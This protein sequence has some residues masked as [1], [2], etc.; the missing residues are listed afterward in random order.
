MR[1]HIKKVAI[2]NVSKTYCF[3]HY[4]HSIVPLPYVSAFA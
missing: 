4:F 3:L 1:S 2:G